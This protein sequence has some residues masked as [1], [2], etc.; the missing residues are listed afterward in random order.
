MKPLRVEQTQLNMRCPRG[1]KVV[2]Y[3]LCQHETFAPKGEF[4]RWDALQSRHMVF[5]A[6]PCSCPCPDCCWGHCISLA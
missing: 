3:S 4:K 1:A 2:K 6:C 5:Q